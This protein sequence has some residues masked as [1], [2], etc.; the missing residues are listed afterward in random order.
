MHCV[1]QK[2]V[3]FLTF[4]AACVIWATLASA[5]KPVPG[6]APDTN[7]IV[8]LHPIGYWPMDEG[9]GNILHDRSGNGKDGKLINTEWE[10]GLVNFEGGY[11]WAEIPASPVYQSKPNAARQAAP[12]KSGVKPPHSISFTIGGWLFSRKSEYKGG[13]TLFVGI[14][15]NLAW[16]DKN[17][18]AYLR[19]GDKGQLDVFSGGKHDAVGSMAGNIAITPDQWQLVLY[20]YE[21]DGTAKLYI[22]GLLVQSANSVPFDADKMKAPMLIAP[23]CSMWGIGS[24]GSLNGSVR[25]LML[26]DRALNAMEVAQLFKKTRP[27][28]TPKVLKFTETTVAVD[29]KPVDL[30]RLP[31]N[32]LELRLAALKRLIHPPGVHPVKA[33]REFRAKAS[34]FRPVLIEAL[35][36]WRTSHLA[37]EG[38]TI[39]ADDEAKAALQEAVPKLV[40]TLL[41]ANAAQDQ[42]LAACA[43]L[44]EMHWLAKDAAPALLKVLENLLERDG[45]RL[46]RVEDLFR[47][48]LIRALLDIDRNNREVR[49]TLGKALAKP[50]LD[51]LNLDKPYLAEVK[52]LVAA[53]RHM[54]ALD[55]CRKLKL[56]EHGCRFFSQNDPRRDDR[57][58]WSPHLRSYTPAA[59]YNG[60]T[61]KLGEGKGYEGS[62]PVTVQEYCEAV[63][64][65]APQYPA[66]T[67]W[68]PDGKSDNLYRVKIT[69]ADAV[70]NKETTYLEGEWF[71]FD[72]SDPKV[73]AWSIGIDKRGYIHIMGGQHNSPNP[74]NYIPGS[75]ERIGLPRDPKSEA[76]PQQLYWVSK[77]PGR[78]DKFEFVGRRNDPR[79]LLPSY[80]NYMNFVQDNNGELY[81]YGRINVSGWQSF[82]LYRYD[83]DTRHW[84]VIGGEACDVIADC[85]ANDPGWTARLVRQVRGQIPRQP[86]EKTIA[87]AWQAHFYN[88]C[89][90][91]WGV[92]FDR[93]NRMHVELGIYGLVD[94]ISMR[95]GNLYAY[96]DDG[97]QTFHRADGSRVELPL[98]VNPAPAHNADLDKHADARWWNLYRSLVDEAG[99]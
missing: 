13:G 35:S 38:L 33:Q 40:E 26:F 61:Y 64:V 8:A 31:K 65:L 7:G 99:Y 87:W 12:E 10:N 95:D 19:I 29:G 16:L 63:K 68:R 78:I 24:P 91:T 17:T 72:G 53:G 98:T 21:A 96:S 36:D 11:Q 83:V 5:D 84:S 51:L 25:D 58:E 43:A 46:L 73:H 1:I 44:G 49:A 32:P 34:L 45:V 90:A 6:P 82:G 55:A 69:K 77:E 30:K 89:R 93:T 9:K 76:F 97:G 18:A 4:A 81:V 37:A 92:R 62:V 54:D 50:F 57:T 85:E 56:S 23:D 47:N 74:A 80:W 71:I 75:W 66:A 42:R 39:L 28:Q 86:G 60:F 22:D 70:G 59:E 27:K 67:G 20:A 94:R 2:Y 52:L 79:H 41:D 14:V 88:Y 15:G 3:R 48:S